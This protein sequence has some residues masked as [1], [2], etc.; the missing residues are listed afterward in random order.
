MS[1]H[2]L[3]GGAALRAG[4]PVLAALVVWNAGN[5]AFFLLAGRALGPSEYGLAADRKSVV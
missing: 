4:G 2:A 3:R 5:Y 1:H